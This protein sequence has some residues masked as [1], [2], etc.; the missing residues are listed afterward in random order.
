MSTT[1]L[2]PSTP[3]STTSST[4]KKSSI[5]SRTETGLRVDE[6]IQE[7]TASEVVEEC[8]TG[9]EHFPAENLQKMYVFR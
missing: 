4:T 5:N 1:T 2:L 8:D 9:A 6:L 3:T 7:V